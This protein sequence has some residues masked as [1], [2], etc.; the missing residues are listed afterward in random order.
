M[1]EGDNVIFFFVCCWG[2]FV[3]GGEIFIYWDIFFIWELIICEGDLVVGCFKMFCVVGV[4]V[5]FMLCFIFFL[6]ECGFGV[7]YIKRDWVEWIQVEVD[8]GGY[9]L[10]IICC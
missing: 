2:I 9:G 7:C 1:V 3:L 10:I 6:M 8:I 5:V 4:I